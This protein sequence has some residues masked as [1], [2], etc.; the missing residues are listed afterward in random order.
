MRVFI[1]SNRQDHQRW[2]ILEISTFICWKLSK[3]QS[4]KSLDKLIVNKK[5]F[6]STKAQSNSCLLMESNAHNMVKAS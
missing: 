4:I 6:L 1:N 3:L 2:E 5:Y